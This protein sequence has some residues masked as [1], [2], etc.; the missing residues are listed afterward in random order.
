MVKRYVGISLPEALV[1]KLD[2]FIR[3][4]PEYQNRSDFVKETIRMRMEEIVKLDNM[5]TSKFR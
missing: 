3:N 5:S 4:H 2:E 1:E